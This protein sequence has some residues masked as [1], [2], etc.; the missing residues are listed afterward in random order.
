MSKTVMDFCIFCGKN[1]EHIRYVED[2]T[3]D[4]MGTNVEYTEMG[5]V[6][7]VCGNETQSVEENND[8]MRQIKENYRNR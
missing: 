3:F 8:S 7:S 4:W 2:R 1:T 5:R 6:C